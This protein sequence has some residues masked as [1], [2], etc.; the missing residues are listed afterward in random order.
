MNYAPLCLDVNESLVINHDS[1]KKTVG[2]G[3]D[4]DYDVAEKAFRRLWTFEH[5]FSNQTWLWTSTNE[6]SEVTRHLEMSL[7]VRVSSF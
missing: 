4:R 6:L 3:V 7:N 2:G 5:N 1:T